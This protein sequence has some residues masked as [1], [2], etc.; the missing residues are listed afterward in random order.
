MLNHQARV[1]TS[2]AL[3]ALLLGAAAPLASASPAGTP[4]PDAAALYGTRCAACHDHPADRI[5][6]RIMLST[7]RTPEE[8]IAALTNGVMRQQA[9][10]LS[11]DDIRAVAVYL[12][13]KEPIAVESDPMAN[14]CTQHG[15]LQPAAGDWSG[16]GRDLANTRLQPQGGLAASDVPRLELKWAFAFPGRSAFGQPVVVGDRLY[17]GG[18][19]GRVYSL[20]AKTGCTHWSYDARAPVRLSKWGDAE[21][22]PPLRSSGLH[23]LG[24]DAR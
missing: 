22:Q 17:A 19:G 4:S 23:R 20:D 5:P 12:T 9:A 16:W 14:A 21:D 2:A 6:S 11:A 24:S 1:L 3:A 13:G 7:Y 10:G 15:A 18:I 8:I